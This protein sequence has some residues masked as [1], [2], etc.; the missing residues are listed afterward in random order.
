MSSSANS[1]P[2]HFFA[3]S[4]F[5]VI[6]IIVLGFGILTR[7]QKQ[8]QEFYRVAGPIIS[9]GRTFPGA[10][11]RHEEKMRYVQVGNYPKAFEL[12][13]GQDPG[14]FSPA[15]EQ[16]D[17]LKAG[18]V[19]TIYYDEEQSQA[20]DSEIVNRLAQ[21]IDKGQKPYFIRGSK[22]KLGG[23]SIIGAGVLI[24]IM[25]LVLKKKGTI[26]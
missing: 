4:M 22:D 21:F 24:G 26:V 12:F 5:G 7:G 15:F 14:D 19:V 11:N 13:I 18:D 3:K 8:K 23:Y 20:G 16:I 17:G 1:Q 10:F 25:L 2:A 9:I 6:T